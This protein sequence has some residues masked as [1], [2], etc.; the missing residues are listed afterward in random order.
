MLVT[1]STD[2]FILVSAVEREVSNQYFLPSKLFELYG[3]LFVLDC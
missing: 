3:G 1:R 2:K